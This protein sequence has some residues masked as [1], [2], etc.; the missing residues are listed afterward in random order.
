[1]A[2]I[3]QRLPSLNDGETYL[4]RV[5]GDAEAGKVLFRRL[6]SL[7]LD[8][9][10]RFAYRY[11]PSPKPAIRHAVREWRCAMYEQLEGEE[12]KQALKEIDNFLGCEYVK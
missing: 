9:S 7:N 3:F 12:L 10:L 6:Q 8:A 4:A 5:P 2:L 1:M 11:G